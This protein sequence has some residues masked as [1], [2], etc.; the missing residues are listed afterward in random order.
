MP[1]HCPHSGALVQDAIKPQRG[2]VSGQAFHYHW[3]IPALLRHASLELRCKTPSTTTRRCSSSACGW[4]TRP[5]CAS[6]CMRGA[7]CATALFKSS[8]SSCAASSASGYVCAAVV[9]ACGRLPIEAIRRL[10]LNGTLVSLLSSL[11]CAQLACVHWPVHFPPRFVITQAQTFQPCMLAHCFLQRGCMSRAFFAWKDRFHIVDKNLAMKRKV[12]TCGS[13]KDRTREGFGETLSSS[14]VWEPFNV[15]YSRLACVVFSCSLEGQEQSRDRSIKQQ[16]GTSTHDVI[17][18][19]AH[20]VITPGG[21]QCKQSAQ[22]AT[23]ISHNCIL[24]AHC[25]LKW[26]LQLRAPS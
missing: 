15:A 1:Y 7:Q 3:H 8:R 20:D 14:L 6:A 13:G 2:A 22:T 21:Y 24:R 25:D 17:V 10:Q 19:G 11:A 12:R 23:S 4:R 18:D 9:V 26:K 16:G 5:R